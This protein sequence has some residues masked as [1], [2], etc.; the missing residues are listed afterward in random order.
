MT[1]TAEKA[2]CSECGKHW[3]ATVV[4]DGICFM[5]QDDLDDE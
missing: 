1:T 5:C 3:D 2:Y 4:E